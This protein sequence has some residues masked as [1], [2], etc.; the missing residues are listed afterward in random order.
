[1]DDF[2]GLKLIL[3]IFMIIMARNRVIRFK[4]VFFVCTI[5]L[6]LCFRFRIFGLRQFSFNELKEVAHFLRG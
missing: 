3:L 1:M 4:I 5:R 2:E 6:Q